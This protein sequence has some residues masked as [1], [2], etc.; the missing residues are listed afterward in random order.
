MNTA[1]VSLL[2]I[3]WPFPFLIRSFKVSPPEEHNRIYNKW[4]RINRTSVDYSL[5]WKILLVSLFIITVFILWN[6]RINRLLSEL[7]HLKNELEEKNKKLNTQAVTDQLTG[8]YNRIKLDE[9]LNS[10]M[11]RYA[12]YNHAFGLILMD[13]DHFKKS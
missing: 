12:R 13:V 6:I 5:V 11:A 7:R 8:L 10:E 3:R 4:I 9:A 1:W 2:K